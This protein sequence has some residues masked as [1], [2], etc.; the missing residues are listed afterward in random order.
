MLVKCPECGREKVSDSALAC[1]DCGFNIREYTEKKKQT[2]N[3]AE[4]DTSCKKY[5]YCTKCGKIY[6]R[7]YDRCTSCDWIN[8]IVESRYPAEYYNDIAREREIKVE[9]IL[10]AEVVKRQGE[11]TDHLKSE[12]K[13]IERPKPKCPKCQSTNIAYSVV[14]EAYTTNKQSEVRKKGVIERKANKLGRAVMTMATAGL[15]SLTP[16][17]SEYRETGKSQTI[18]KQKTVAVCQNCGHSW[19]R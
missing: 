16:K 3:Q 4:V 19:D 10:N 17:A 15:W 2:I 7:Y 11:H 1:P 9:D 5:Y 14:N 8:H 12:I 18:I 13:D 6:I